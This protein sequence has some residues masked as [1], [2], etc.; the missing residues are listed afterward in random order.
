MWT[1]EGV[2]MGELRPWKGLL[3]EE[4][5]EGWTCDVRETNLGMSLSQ[6][7]RMMRAA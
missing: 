1:K 3:E 7:H 6:I 2:Q 5:I 4:T